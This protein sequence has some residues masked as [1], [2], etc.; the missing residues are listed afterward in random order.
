MLNRDYTDRTLRAVS[1]D[2]TYPQVFVDG[3]LIGDSDNLAAWLEERQKAA[4]RSAA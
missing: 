1:T 2:H 3:K 4:T